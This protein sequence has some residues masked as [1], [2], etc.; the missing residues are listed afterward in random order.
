MVL[1][2]WLIAVPSVGRSRKAVAVVRQG[3]VEARWLTVDLAVSQ[4]HVDGG[5]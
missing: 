4:G 1:V 3:G 5:T 2:G